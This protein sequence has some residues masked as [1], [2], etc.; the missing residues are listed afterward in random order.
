MIGPVTPSGTGGFNK[1]GKAGSGGR[2][3]L[4]AHGHLEV[5]ERDLEILAWVTRHGIVT[6]EQIARKFFPTSS[7]LSAAFQRVRKLATASPPLLRRDRTH[8]REPSVIRVT[9]HG[10]R[11]ANVGPPALGPARLILAE[12]HH[13]LGI[14]D[15]TEELLKAHPEA[16]LTT[17][18]ERRA[19]RHAQKRAGQRKGTG[20]IPDA[21]L[22]LPALG[23]KAEQS[24]A[25][26]LDRSPRTQRDIEAIVRAYNA[27]RYT[28][29]WWYVRPRRV[30]HVREVIQ[31][32][33]ASDFIEVRPWQGR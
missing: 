31:K 16:A 12:V 33:R 29:V 13:S 24:V 3:P 22:T 28:D 11:L 17:E 10:A 25:V 27:E 21:V 23:G 15:L 26:E 9:T 18:R 7:G 4:R 19:E 6:V 1:P 2:L 8:Y 30:A 5:T 14:V 20:R 32:L